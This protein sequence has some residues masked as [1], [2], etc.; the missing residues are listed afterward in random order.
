V[1]LGQISHTKA[2]FMNQQRE[3]YQMASSFS[4]LQLELLT[5][6]LR[7]APD[8]P[9]LY[10]FICAPANANAAFE[11]DA[12]R[13]LDNAIERSIPEFK[14]LARMVAILGSFLTS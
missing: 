10:R 2:Q 4:R 5:I 7:H 6:I 1:L 8:L 13:I 3:H 9:S 11:I 14:H 12:D